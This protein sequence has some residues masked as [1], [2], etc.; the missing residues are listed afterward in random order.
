MKAL[1]K[2]KR[3]ELDLI[4]AMTEDATLAAATKLSKLAPTSMHD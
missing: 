3:E 4:A 2:R 1:T